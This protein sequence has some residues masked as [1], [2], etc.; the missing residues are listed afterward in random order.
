V[1]ARESEVLDLVGKGLTNTQIG[2]RLFISVRTVESHV[3]SLL[4][5]LDLPDR[6]ALAAHI[7]A[8][9][10]AVTRSTR[11][12][13]STSLAFVRER[14]LP[15]ASLGEPVPGSGDGSPHGRRRPLVGGRGRIRGH[16]RALRGSEHTGVV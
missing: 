7:G 1:S 4:R 5:K 9:R 8:R 11:S 16:R 3:S 12:G 10:A 14:R 13:S 15:R 6:H 2:T